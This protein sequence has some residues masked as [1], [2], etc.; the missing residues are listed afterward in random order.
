VDS[1]VIVLLDL[2]SGD[3]SSSRHSCAVALPVQSRIMA[4]VESVVRFDC[5]MV[6]LRRAANHQ[7]LHYID[8][9]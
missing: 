9:V 6:A 7:F 2:E 5:F 4:V 8:V 3:Q 1:D